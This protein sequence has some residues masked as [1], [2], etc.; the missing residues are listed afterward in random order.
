MYLVEIRGKLSSRLE[1]MEDILT[2]NVF[3]FFEYANRTVFLKGYLHELG[4]EICEHEAIEV[5]FDF[6]PRYEDS[7]RN[8]KWSAL[9]CAWNCIPTASRQKGNVFMKR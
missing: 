2:S 9:T 3:S 1:N 4:F 5:V 7:T 8:L 6:W